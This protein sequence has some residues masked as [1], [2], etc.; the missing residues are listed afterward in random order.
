MKRPDSR[1]VQFEKRIPASVRDL[2]VGRT[3]AVPL[4]AETILITITPRMEAVRLSLRTTDP[5]EA[6]ARRRSVCSDL[7]A[8]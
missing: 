1:F 7:A 6:Q 3:L 8:A 5:G 4:G 2:A